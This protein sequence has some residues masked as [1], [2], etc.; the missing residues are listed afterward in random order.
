[1]KTPL[2]LPTSKTYS[3]VEQCIYCGKTSCKLSNEH[4][5]PFGLGG[6]LVLPRSSCQPCSDITS[7]IELECLRKMLMHTRT[8][9]DMPTRRPK[10]RPTHLPVGL[11]DPVEGIFP[12][13]MR[14]ANFRWED[15]PASEHPSAA[16][17]PKFE[18][19]T[20][21]TGQGPSENFIL[22][23]FNC[24]LDGPTPPG[25]EGQKA[26]IFMPFEPAIF[27]RMLA[28][29]GHAAAVAELGFKSFEPMLSGVILGTSRSISHLV[30]SSQ[31][32]KKPSDSTHKVCLALRSG[33]IVAYVTLFAHYGFRPYEVVV[34]KPPKDWLYLSTSIVLQ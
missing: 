14:T 7:R 34:G 31:L 21:L 23:G 10:E 2:I 11:F 26:G 25:S 22:T 33:Y 19:P 17:L 24:H 18:R 6:R 16:L 4:I 27:C 20:I 29:I 3:A 13:D 1:M 8:K 15:R 30:G 32:K 9:H 12:P 5:I 28:K